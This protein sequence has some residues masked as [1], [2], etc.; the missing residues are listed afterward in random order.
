MR[1]RSSKESKV[2]QNSLRVL[3]ILQIINFYERRKIN[4]NK[5]QVLSPLLNFRKS[6]KCLLNEVP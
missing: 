6:R 2:K 3:G 1:T 5:I 4:S